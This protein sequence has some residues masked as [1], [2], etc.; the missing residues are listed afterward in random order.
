MK[1][2]VG[3]VNHCSNDDGLEVASL[4]ATERRLQA[5]RSSPLHAGVSRTR[6]DA[7]ELLVVPTQATSDFVMRR[8]R[9]R[10][11]LQVQKNNTFM[12]IYVEEIPI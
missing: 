9:Q 8:E 5:S 7:T 10:A 4:A 1:N 3:S 11:F 12:T 6:A 2:T